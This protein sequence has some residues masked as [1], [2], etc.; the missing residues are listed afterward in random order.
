MGVKFE[1]SPQLTGM[2]LAHVNRDYIADLIFKK[3][4]VATKTFGYTEFLKDYNL[5]VPD[6][7]VGDKGMP[8]KIDYKGKKQLASVEGHALLDEISQSE[9]DEA[10]GNSE[11]LE[12]T[13]TLFLT[14][15]FLASRE[16]RLADLLSN[17]ETYAGNTKTLTAQQKI[18]LATV[19]AVDIVQDAIDTCWIKPN[20]MI[21]GRQA[22]SKFRRNPFVVKGVN[23]N[24]GDAGIASMEAI[25]ELFELDDIFVGNSM[26]NTA[27][28]GQDANFVSLWGNDIILAYINPNP[29][30]KKDLT[31][32]VTADF[33]K[34]ELST[35]FDGM[36]GTRGVKYVKIAE[37][38]KDLIISPDC[39]Y[40]LKNVL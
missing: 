35:A 23:H 33:G 10:K 22:F 18:S 38:N 30:L 40:L 3:V 5:M 31:F 26:A 32:G 13:S 21:A 19:N 39:G 17:P 12:E 28:R 2:S 16:K 29:S 25:K 20:V 36:P 8:N 6:T 4:A 14:N 37:E 24:S 9:I 1:V 11:N 7:L 34:R 27:K 15:N